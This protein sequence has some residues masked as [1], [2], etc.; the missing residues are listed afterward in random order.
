MTRGEDRTVG[1]QQGG[2][3][4]S[5]IDR[6]TDTNTIFKH[7]DAR[8]LQ[9]NV[10]SISDLEKRFL[11]E[12]QK[13]DDAMRTKRATVNRNGATTL[14]YD[15]HNDKRFQQWREDQERVREKLQV[16]WLDEC[17]DRPFNTL[18]YFGRI[19]TTAGLFYGCGR[20]VYLYRTMDVAYAKL[21]GISIGSICLTE[22]SSAVCK[23]AAVA[24]TSSVGVVA[25]D[26]F[27][28]L[29]SLILTRD[30]SAPDR[31]WPHFALSGLCSGVMG[32]GTLAALHYRTLTP[33][34]M[35]AVVAAFTVSFTT[36]G[37]AAGYFFYQPFA[38]SRTHKL[39]E[40]YWRSWSDRM[41]NYGGPHHVR[42]RYT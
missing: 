3:A 11:P 37:A 13:A 27:A 15:Y 21:C 26:T 18:L 4:F 8:A 6:L 7:G 10:E 29:S 42:G 16:H 1:G 38:A 28:N 35:R 39:Y 12:F 14:L 30:A 9:M 19:F 17:L 36:I 34:G 40:P 23:G 24:V 22:V 5:P 33:W 20:T 41:V 31:S 32:G 2:I 25:G